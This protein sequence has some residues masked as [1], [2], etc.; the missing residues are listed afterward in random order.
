MTARDVNSLGFLS[1]PSG[2]ASEPY[3]VP[4]VEDLLENGLFALGTTPTHIA[5]HGAAHACS[6][7]CDWGGI[8]RTIQQR[9]QAIRF[10]LG[11]EDDEPLGSPSQVETELLS[12]LK[13][14]SP[15][16]FASL[17]SKYTALARGGFSDDILYLTCFVDY[18]IRDYLLGDGPKSLTVAYDTWYDLPSY[19]IYQEQ[20]EAGLGMVE[21]AQTP[22]E[23][24]DAL[25]RRAAEFEAPL[26]NAVGDREGV[27]FIAPLGAHGDISVE[28]WQAVAQ[29]ELQEDAEGLLHAA[30]YGA[31]RHDPEYTQTYDNLKSRVTRA[32]SSDSLADDRVP[33]VDGLKGYYRE[34]G[35]YSDITP[36]DGS[37]DVFTPA[38]PPPVSDC[39]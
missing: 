14:V 38:E 26:I 2:A 21:G 1:G 11:L 25:R 16:H 19:D 13:N 9:E 29:W 34:I 22:L 36:D 17:A 12:Y 10:W 28:A 23:Y 5:F 4:T 31:P 24:E 32:T 6:V 8:A 30:R 27:V 33:T 7:R 3:D 35:A 37:D 18:T 20:L 15:K 39:S